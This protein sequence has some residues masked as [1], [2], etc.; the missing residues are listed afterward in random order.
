[1][2]SLT[3]IIVKALFWQIC[4]SQTKDTVRVYDYLKSDDKW[5][6]EIKNNKTFTF[7]TN[8]LFSKD[9]VTIKGTCK[10]V[11]SAIQFLCDTLIIREKYLLRKEFRQ[12]SN[13]PFI[14][15]GDTFSV[16]DKFFIPRNINYETDDSIIMPAGIY[17]KY[18]QGDGFWSNI[19]E[20]RED[21][22]YT[23]SD[24]SCTGGFNEEGT[25]T[26]KDGMLLF[27]PNKEKWSM[28]DR[29]TKDRKL[30]LTESHLVGKKVSKAGTQE[31]E[32]IVVE[33]FYYLSKRPRYLNL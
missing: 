18:Y 10:I 7:Y 20:L 30:F 15:F 16:Q 26:L 25:W 1:M 24:F 6:L 9:E 8:N 13:I 12:F 5:K 23:F 14:L 11:D 33:T 21:G 29:I 3:T 31:K 28:L 22:T 32:T 4:F 27:R 2:K 19:I 17:A